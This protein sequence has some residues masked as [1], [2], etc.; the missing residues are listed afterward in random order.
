MT[1]FGIVRPL[2][3]EVEIQ[4]GLT[5][6]EICLHH[7]YNSIHGLEACV[8]RWPFKEYSIMAV[9]PLYNVAMTLYSRLKDSCTHDLFA[10]TCLH[11]AQLGKDFPFTS[12]L[13]QGL[14]AVTEES[15]TKVPPEVE[16]IFRASKLRK[17]DLHDV[18][19]SFVLP[20]REQIF[21]MLD[22]EAAPR[23]DPADGKELGDL[24]AK[25]SAMSV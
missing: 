4:E 12:F 15:G 13:L 11:L 5:S 18:P 3:P 7:C 20:R 23:S 22:G 14:R 25:W 16:Q 6:G 1:V 10:R 21:E 24:I 9:Y 19:I 17:E 2:A 8:K